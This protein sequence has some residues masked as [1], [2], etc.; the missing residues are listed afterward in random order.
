MK[1]NKE[2]VV[3]GWLRTML[4]MGYRLEFFVNKD[5]KLG[6]ILPIP[7]EN[8]SYYHTGDDLIELIQT[9]Y[10]SCVQMQM[11]RELPDKINKWHDEYTR[12]F[13]A[14]FDTEKKDES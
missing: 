6:V 13:L 1:V 12:E 3:L 2:Q 14:D 4:C 9:C 8:K 10:R 7:N 5:K 11:E